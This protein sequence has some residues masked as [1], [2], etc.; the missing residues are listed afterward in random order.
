[1][2]RKFYT[3]LLS[4]AGALSMN[5]QSIAF[6]E[7]FD[8]ATYDK[9]FVKVKDGDDAQPNA[10]MREIGF[11]IGSPWVAVKDTEESRDMGFASTSA[12]QFPGIQ[13]DDWLYSRVIDIP[14]GGYVLSFDAQSFTTNNNQ[15]KLSDLRVY[16]STKGYDD[17]FFAATPDF[18]VKQVPTGPSD[19]LEGEYTHYE[20]PLDKY[21]GMPIIIA[22]VNQN[23]DKE[24]LVIDNVLVARDDM[25]SLDMKGHRRYSTD[26]AF[27]PA[28]TV[29]GL[30][31]EPLN[32]FRL[33][34]TCDGQ[35]KQTKTVSGAGLTT[36]KS[37]DVTFDPVGMDMYSTVNFSIALSADNIENDIVCS[38]AV[39]R[40][41]YYPERKVVVEEG[42][43]TWC[44]NCP[45]G[46]YAMSHMTGDPEMSK[47]VIGI[48][49]HNND[50]M[51]LAEYDSKLGLPGF[52]LMR[53]N[54]S[55]ETYSP[56]ADD[57]SFG[58]GSGVY[59][60]QKAHEEPTYVEVA[61]T[62]EFTGDNQI[63]CKASV[64]NAYNI[65]DAKYRLAFVLTEN[66]VKGDSRDYRQHNY[67]SN[68]PDLQLGG[69]EK[70]PDVVSG[71]SYHEVARLADTF[72]GIEGSVPA[73]MEAGKEYT[74]SRVITIPETVQDK[75]Y[76]ELVV[77]VI[78]S[79]T[80]EIMNADK[81]PMTEE[82][83]NKDPLPED[84]GAG[85]ED[86]GI[87]YEDDHTDC[88]APH[89]HVFPA[90][91]GLAF[92]MSPSGQYIGMNLQSSAAAPATVYDLKTHKYHT[93]GDDQ[94]NDSRV[95]AITDGGLVAGS[96]N[97]KPVVWSI[98]TGE[99]TYLP[100]YGQTYE[101]AS[102]KGISADGGIV[103]GDGF[104]LT[105]EGYD[106]RVM[107]WKR[108]GAD[109]GYRGCDIK[110]PAPADGL[111]FQFVQMVGMSTDGKTAFG[112]ATSNYGE[113]IPVVWKADDL[114]GCTGE[115][116]AAD[117]FI[118][119]DKNGKTSFIGN[120]IDEG[121]MSCD[122]K[123]FSFM[124]H[125]INSKSTPCMYNTE[126]KSLTAYHNVELP[127]SDYCKNADT[128]VD[129]SGPL[130]NMIGALLPD[131]R[132]VT[133]K[134]QGTIFRETIIVSPDGTSEDIEEYLNR[135]YNGLSIKKAGLDT[136]G[137]LLCV[138]AD[139]NV[140]AGWAYSL[141]QELVASFYV[142]TC[143]ED[144]GTSGITDVNADAADG[145]G[146]KTE[147]YDLQGRRVSAP[148]AGIYIKKTGSKVVKT[149]IRK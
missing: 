47:Y 28:V 125:D 13:S 54:R 141:Q 89:V 148:A 94:T 29:T 146:A 142:N 140:F 83:E 55:A 117:L 108:D 90:A 143:R 50:P 144:L 44:G 22:F 27:T 64:K 66:N 73:V 30:K 82:A 45:L 86:P 17:K 59:A 87:D 37:M 81:L 1:M 4:L 137:T 24:I 52:P 35:V 39:T 57:F 93:F 92:A 62:G 96:W 32:D 105:D 112:R 119:K 139:G 134:G 68:R 46:A 48:A 132:V 138:S 60:A 71:V 97:G 7:K 109:G 126:T 19:K 36:G 21:A 12:Y 70:L 42:T 76:L 113:I 101:S 80:G 38:G 115:Y 133:M 53:I 2:R 121:V 8:D 122:G 124:L 69:W 41:A 63:S 104:G 23:T 65:N 129:V 106:G 58:A 56:L 91:T 72:E 118:A 116:A 34:L 43:G 114:E 98:A 84:G 88:T 33:T 20:F 120:M 149:L 67:F 11:Q 130:G 61:L 79:E 18:E 74:F 6:S 77:M 3:L 145:E 147:Y 40:I 123:Q 75:R 102:A 16:I 103:V 31:S 107:L 25:A 111:P 51:T 26:A 14:T 10:F 78:D 99:V 100:T 136:S 5:A 49:V 131:G 110:A 135:E 9:N 127:L 128:K 15:Q 85:G 95:G